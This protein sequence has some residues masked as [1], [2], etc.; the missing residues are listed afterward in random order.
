[1][2]APGKPQIVLMFKR[3]RSTLK[4]GPGI[5]S[6]RPETTVPETGMLLGELHCTHFEG[7]TYKA[8]E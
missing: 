3:A 5:S 2:A 6:H 1:M 4:S 7:F 8:Q